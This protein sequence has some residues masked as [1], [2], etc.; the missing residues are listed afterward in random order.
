[1]KKILYLFILGLIIWLIKLSY[2][3]FSLQEKVE[4]LQQTQHKSEQL[5]ASLNDQLVAIQRSNQQVSSQSNPPQQN[6]N[7]QEIQSEINPI[8]LLS[9]KLEL[10]QFA[11]DQHEFVYA[12]EQLNQL[13]QLVERLALADTLQVSMHRAVEHDQKMIQQYVVAKNI[14]IAQL[15]DLLENIDANLKNEQQVQQLTSDNSSQSSWFERVFKVERVDE[16]MPVLLNRRLVLKEV[17]LRVLFAQRALQQG[18]YIDYQNAL[19][20]IID[21]LD[22][23]PDAV[24]IKIKNKAKHLKQAQLLPVPKLNSKAILEG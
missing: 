16:Q 10:I 4:L 2:D 18:Q 21:E 14:Q 15:G 1:M 8:K 5:V 3:H 19:T 7:Q 6:N 23:L 22:Q 9:Q 20:S 11:L 24:A 13:D 17:Q 12:L